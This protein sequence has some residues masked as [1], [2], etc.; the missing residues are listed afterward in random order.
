GAFLVY[1]SQVL[2]IL[3]RRVQL[4]LLRALG[5]TRGALLARL[6]AEGAAIGAAG[7][8]LGLA[9]GYALARLLVSLVGGDLGGGYFRSVAT[10]LEADSQVM[11]GFFA[12]GVLF[13]V[14]GA[15][16]PAWEA[17]H[18][19]PAQGL[20]SGDEEQSSGASRA[21]WWGLG[22]FL[23]AALLAQA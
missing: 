10:S 11:A 14:L 3:R 13:A 6:L 23:A 5:V 21:H 15:A 7:S 4:A 19:P 9:L 17:A 16:L 12:L 20:R 1:S 22:A 18:R 8:L 2:A